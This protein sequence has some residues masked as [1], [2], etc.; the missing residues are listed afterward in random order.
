MVNLSPGGK[1]RRVTD[2][3][4]EYLV[5]PLTMIV[6][7]VLNGSQGPLY[8]PPEEIARTHRDW[9]GVPL[10][11]YHPT[12]NGRNVS[13]RSPGVLEESGV[14]VVRNARVRKDGALVAEGWFDVTAVRNYDK[15]LAAEY[16]PTLLPRIQRGEPV[17]LST[18]LFTDNATAPTTFKDHK[19]NRYSG[20]VARNYRPDHLAVL[21]D[22]RGACSLTDGCGVMVNRRAPVF[23]TCQLLTNEQRRDRKGRFASGGGGGAAG[24]G[25]EKDRLA[26]FM[27][28][29]SFKAMDAEEKKQYQDYSNKVKS[30]DRYDKQELGELLDSV[31]SK[32]IPTIPLPKGKQTRSPESI[33]KGKA[34]R[35][36]N[37]EE[38]MKAQAESAKR[39]EYER[40]GGGIRGMFY[41]MKKAAGDVASFL[42][43]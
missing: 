29:D 21:P 30:G 18:G 43:E 34:T 33:A 2:N 13:A 14:G 32:G 19:G 5:A 38:N 8:Y 37:K 27:K 15:R 3:G 22:Q 35:Q 25:D 1:P 40:G 28:S 24:K 7:G 39:Q 20:M 41:R 26:K 42:F 9:E 16:R 10:V 31:E 11:V 23:E 6:P 17:E 4:R 12:R 36:K